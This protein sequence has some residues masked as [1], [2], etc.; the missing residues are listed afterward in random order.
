MP[1]SISAKNRAS[2][3]RLIVMSRS[4]DGRDGGVSDGD[5]GGEGEDDTVLEVSNERTIK[6]AV[7]VSVT[8][9]TMDVGVGVVVFDPGI[10]ARRLVVR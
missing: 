8:R 7:S 1:N 6:L 5:E 9:R 2:P 10:S 3:G 4:R